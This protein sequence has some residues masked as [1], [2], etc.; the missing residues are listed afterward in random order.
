MV[1]DTLTG[2]LGGI[3]MWNRAVVLPNN[4]RIC[5][6]WYLLTLLDVESIY[7][8]CE[9]WHVAVSISLHSLPVMQE[10]RKWSKIIS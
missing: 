1:F 7:V 4:S 8:S 5:K 6:H 3:I 9:Q 2:D 10:P